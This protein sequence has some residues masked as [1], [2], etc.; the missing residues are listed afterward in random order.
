MRVISPTS[1][2]NFGAPAF[3]GLCILANSK[4]ITDTRMD[5]AS[6]KNKPP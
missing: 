4:C 6:S 5:T 2:E 1:D 3:R